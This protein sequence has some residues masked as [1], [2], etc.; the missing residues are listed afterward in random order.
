[1]SGSIIDQRQAPLVLED[2]HMV[3]AAINPDGTTTY[4]LMSPNHG[5]GDGGECIV[6]PRH[7]HTGPL[8]LDITHTLHSNRCGM[9]TVN[10]PPCRSLVAS[11]GKAC[12][13]HEHATSAR[14]GHVVDS[15]SA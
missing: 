12:H 2:R 14:R 6:I 13:H 10:G 5:D 8:P 1:M 11:P 3:V 15:Q 7:E 4:W 9:P